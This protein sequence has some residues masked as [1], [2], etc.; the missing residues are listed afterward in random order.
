[1]EQQGVDTQTGGTPRHTDAAVASC[2]LGIGA[3]EQSDKLV[4]FG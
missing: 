3:L 1:M 4:S 2:W